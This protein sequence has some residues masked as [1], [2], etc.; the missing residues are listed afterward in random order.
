[1][2]TSK[3]AAQIARDNGLSLADAAALAKLCTTVEEA[4]QCASMFASETPADMNARIR[5]K[6]AAAAE[7]REAAANAHIR[8]AER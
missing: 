6:I 7:K 2:L 4:Q 3:E 1:M 8:R 5:G